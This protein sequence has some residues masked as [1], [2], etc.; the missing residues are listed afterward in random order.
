MFATFTDY[1][2]IR[3]Q[4]E[5]RLMFS[6]DHGS[7]LRRDVESAFFEDDP[8]PRVTSEEKSRPPAQRFR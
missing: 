2:V 7:A 6:I 5:G 3:H 4:S 1:Q 8:V